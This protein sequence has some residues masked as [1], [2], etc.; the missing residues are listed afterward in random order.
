MKIINYTLEANGQIPSFIIDGGYFPVA[1]SNPSP[2]DFTMIG[3]ANDDAVGY[4]YQSQQELIDYLSTVG[5]DWVIFEPAA[6]E[7]VP[8][9]PIE[10]A[11][12]M[13]AKLDS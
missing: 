4:E 8:F 13:W 7:F 9:N 5:A 11:S 2:Q 3:L 10:S 6:N 1:N 12:M